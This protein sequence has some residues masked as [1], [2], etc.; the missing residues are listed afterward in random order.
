MLR[1]PSSPPSE[2][3]PP[4]AEERQPDI[5]LQAATLD[6]RPLE[7]TRGEAKT[8]L[9]VPVL[10]RANLRLTLLLPVGSSEGDYEFEIRDER[11]EL[12]LRGSGNAIIRDYITTIETDLDLRSIRPGRLVL[13]IRRGGDSAWRTYSFEV[14]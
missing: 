8:G 11:G 14:Q 10:T 2:P 7:P 3:P 5:Q 13:A 12:Q 6:L 9:P 1:S 4:V